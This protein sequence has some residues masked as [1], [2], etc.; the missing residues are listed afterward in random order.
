MRILLVASDPME[1]RG[2]AALAEGAHPMKLAGLDWSCHVRLGAHELML[3]A[4][5]IGW[6]CAAE[7]VFRGCGMFDAERVVSTGFCGA[8]DPDLPLGGV[9]VATSIAG[10]R[11]LS[12]ALPVSGG[13]P[14]RAGPVCSVDH[15]VRT[16]DEK[17]RLG[18]SGAIAVEME[19]AGVA[20]AAES[21]HLPFHC[22]RSVTDLAG[23]TMANDFNAALRP[24][25]H[26][27]TMK[28]LR[29]S[30]REPLV[31]LPELFRLRSRCARAARVLG[32]FF[33][34]CRF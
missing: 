6:K 7:A 26:F 12:P 30:L 28:I 23:E 22:V 1:L 15:V 24:D 9:V 17:C 8:L 21:R 20:A 19:A 27:G 3:A 13:V 5:G 16:A 10:R 33:A 31:R 14:H 34:D 2:I 11:R 32:E 25:G 29:A 4:N 18:A